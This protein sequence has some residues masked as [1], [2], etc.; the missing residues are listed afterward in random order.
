MDS[1][2]CKFPL[3]TGYLN[4]ISLELA[5]LDIE[6]GIY[7]FVIKTKKK[8]IFEAPTYIQKFIRSILN[9]TDFYSIVF[10]KYENEVSYID[11]DQD[12]VFDIYVDTIEDKSYQ[13]YY[14][15]SFENRLKYNILTIIPPGKNVNALIFNYPG[16]YRKRSSMIFLDDMIFNTF[17]HHSR[18]KGVCIVLHNNLHK[19]CDMVAKFIKI[20]TNMGLHSVSQIYNG[21]V[22]CVLFFSFV[23]KKKLCDIPFSVQSDVTIIEKILVSDNIHR[24]IHNSNDIYIPFMCG[25]VDGSD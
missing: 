10:K 17:C 15:S 25:G 18:T 1:L 19:N 21:V 12:S 4:G 22:S 20:Q 23:D 2:V 16:E 11:Y 13:D 9:T 6:C 24:Y 14:I 5:K 8:F 7:I 3:I